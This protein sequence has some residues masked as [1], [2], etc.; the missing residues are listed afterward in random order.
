MVPCAWALSG[1]PISGQVVDQSTGKPVRDAIVVVHWNGTWPRFPVESITAC[2]HVETARTDANGV[3]RIPAWKR[4]WSISDLTFTAEPNSYRVF[5]PGYTL[6]DI[7]A[8]STF[9]M[10]PYAGSVGWYFDNVLSLPGWTCHRAREDRKNEYRLFKA[11]ADEAQALA[12]TPD[13]QSLADMLRERAEMSLVNFDKP[14]H[15]VRSRFQNVD[16]KDAFKRE[17]V[18]Q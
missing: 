3:Y 16:P 6:R 13:Q 5:K 10:A 4:P 2:Y 14:T 9:S 7:V 17:E 12:E 1:G 18:P 11:M 15:S 8:G